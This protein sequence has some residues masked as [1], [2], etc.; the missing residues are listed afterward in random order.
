MDLRSLRFAVTLAEELHFAR[1]AGRHYIAAQAFGRQIRRLERDLGT[2]LF[3][4]TSRRVE[5]TAAD[6]RVITRAHGLLADLDRLA[7]EA[8]DGD[9]GGGAP[10]RVGVLGFGAAER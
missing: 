5:L 3:H 7:V 10:L 2:T 6:E 9:P 8:A 1:A 4:R